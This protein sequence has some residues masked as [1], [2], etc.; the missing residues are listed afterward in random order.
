MHM[1]NVT[2]DEKQTHCYVVAKVMSLHKNLDVFKRLSLV[3]V[4]VH[5][6]KCSVSLSMRIG[7]VCVELPFQSSRSY[8]MKISEQSMALLIRSIRMARSS[9]WNDSTMFSR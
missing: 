4:F 2:I 3:R 7:S 6:L 1:K 8:D 9:R 5:R